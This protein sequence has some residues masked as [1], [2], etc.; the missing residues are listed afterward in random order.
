MITKRAKLWFLIL[1]AA[2][3]IV[4]TI[5]VISMKRRVNKILQKS[6]EITERIDNMERA[7]PEQ[8][9]ELTNNQ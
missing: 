3:L 9:K 4:I 8:V 7:I 1:V 6:T 2:L 5:Q